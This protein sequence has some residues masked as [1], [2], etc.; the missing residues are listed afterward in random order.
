[1]ECG[2]APQNRNRDRFSWYL[3]AD[4]ANAADEKRDFGTSR[5]QLLCKS[6]LA[7]CDGREAKCGSRL[8]RPTS[9]PEMESAANQAR[10]CHWRIFGG[11]SSS[12]AL[13]TVP[14][15]SRLPRR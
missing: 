5:R 2:M 4:G 11:F 15:I 6:V 3:P 7:H 10:S 12:M 9:P 1:M 13:R 14:E 8:T